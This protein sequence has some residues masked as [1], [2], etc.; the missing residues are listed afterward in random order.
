MEIMFEHIS[1]MRDGQIVTERYL[2]HTAT[3]L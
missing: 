3:R 1:N 2:F